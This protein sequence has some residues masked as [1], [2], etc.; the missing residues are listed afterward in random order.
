MA[1][2][3]MK[4]EWKWMILCTQIVVI[5]KGKY[6]KICM[7]NFQMSFYTDI[8]AVQLTFTWIQPNMHTYVFNR[9]AQ[10]KSILINHE[11]LSKNVLK[12]SIYEQRFYI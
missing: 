8:Q 4:M 5:R 3:R 7:S 10:I 12:T 11:S 2:D 9:S 6:E 1:M